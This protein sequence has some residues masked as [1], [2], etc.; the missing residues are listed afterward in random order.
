MSFEK[1][2][3]F[4]ELEF[5]RFAQSLVRCF[6]RSK[7]DDLKHAHSREF[8]SHS[9]KQALSHSASDSARQHLPAL[10]LSR[11]GGLR[12]ERPASSGSGSDREKIVYLSTLAGSKPA[13]NVGFRSDLFTGARGTG[14]GKCHGDRR[15]RVRRAADVDWL[16]SCLAILRQAMG[17]KR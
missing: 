4:E 2:V 7:N 12:F 10:G 8:T 15:T 13:N 9:N 6:E 1:L 5:V 3:R 11:A 16:D 14:T 17:K